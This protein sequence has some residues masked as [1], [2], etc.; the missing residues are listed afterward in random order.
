LKHRLPH[1]VVETGFLDNS[2][3]EA[4]I[5]FNLQLQQCRHGLLPSV[6]I[7]S[8]LPRHYQ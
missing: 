3:H 7:T 8:R 2:S 1:E 6:A 4:N 5:P